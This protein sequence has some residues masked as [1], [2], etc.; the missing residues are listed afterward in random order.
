MPVSP[1][2]V[3]F[4]P[5]VKALQQ[6]KG[7]RDAYA[8]MEQRRP[9][10]DRIT[11]DLAQFIA[12]QTSVFLGTANAAGQPYIQHRG[13]P[14]GFLKVLGSHEI[15]FADLG[16]NKQYITL[17]NLSDNPQAI[18]FLMDYERARRVKIWGTARV[19][20]EDPD[21]VELLSPDGGAGR[22]ERAIFLTVA[23][24][25]VNCPQHIPKRF[26]AER[27]AALLAERDAKIAHLVGELRRHGIQ[28]DESDH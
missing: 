11:P 14:P 4:S 7:S 18:L 9:W 5:T 19:V 15:G 6:A 20:E 12:A 2:D 23:A 17:G 8:R 24:W 22:P 28:P 27:V 25:D 16:G 10:P 1:S 21:L 13:G 26:D 3:A